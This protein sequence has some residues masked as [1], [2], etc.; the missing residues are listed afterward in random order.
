MPMKRIVKITFISLSI[1]IVLIFIALGF[2]FGGRW[3]S[4]SKLE[5][6]TS[7]LT[8]PS[9]AIDIYDSSNRTIKDENMFNSNYIKQT[10]I[11][12]HVKDAFIS[13]E[14]KTFYLHHG[15]NYKRIAKAVI[16][17]FKSM[18]LKEGASTISQQ[19]IKNTHL[20][21][22]KTF[23]RKIKEIALTKKLE[24]KYSKDEILEQ[25][26]NV[27]YFGNNCYGI[28]SAS[29]FYFSKSAH[30]LNLQE[31]AM[32][33][34]IIKSPGKYSPIANPSNCL[35]RR[36]LV[37]KEME[38]DDKITTQEYMNAKNSELG[39]KLNLKTENKLNS[40]S[41]ASIDEAE[42]IL[43]IPA[44]Q[45]ALR[46]YQI[47]TYQNNEKQQI[48]EKAFNSYEMGE[49][50]YAG[51][52]I[53]NQK[54]AVEAYTGRSAYK[55]INT[56]RQPGSCIKPILVY[57]PALNED[58]IT[59]C[60]QLLD[61]KTEIS[62]YTPRNIGDKYNGYVSAREALAKSINI[63]AVKVL[64]Y[65]GIDKAKAYAE[66][67]GIDFS[68][69]DDNY[70]LAL[71]GMCNGVNINQLATA[72]SCLANG[73]IY[74]PSH[75]VSYITDKNDKLIYVHRPEEKRVLREDASYLMTDMLRTSAKTGT[76]RKLS[77][78]EIDIASKT[79]TVGKSGVK[80]NLDAWNMSYTR[81]YTCGVWVG[82]L[83]NT[84]ITAVGG[85]LPTMIVKNY[86]SQTN[87]T[88]IFEQ[89]SSIVSMPI[90][91]TELDENHKVVLAS[92]FTP[93]RYT[94][95]ELFSRFNLPSE[96][97]NKFTQIQQPELKGNVIGDKA[98]LTFDAKNYYEYKLYRN[99]INESNL[100]ETITDKQG[101]QT[102]TVSM[103]LEREKFILVASFKSQLNLEQSI[104]TT[105]D[106]IK[107]I[108]TNHSH[109]LSQK[110]YV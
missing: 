43:G 104:S 84:P 57:A 67:L 110:W 20:S 42:K 90:D 30:D 33:A 80:D 56:K 47:H 10:A 106:L 18:N 32:L 59:P 54:H 48:L 26:L 52:V 35:T 64:S 100:I 74:A 12:N 101:K 40:Y 24:K 53:N 49:D 14:D 17:N 36:N 88:S 8:S 13:I 63:P 61:E 70:A 3:L 6:D 75:F 39:L 73:G 69:G 31:G 65:I 1:L 19:L 93:E 21:S 109:I 78:L 86:F 44:K 91:T 58:I 15:I 50:D 55:I 9:L 5:L 102:L 87:D 22:E 96:I 107:S 23:D 27:I 51:I 11:P 7:K 94:R 83:D 81:N 71:G 103:P 76:A 16:N 99:T 4:Y 77:D 82:N 85:G 72:Y 2:Y 34:G 29:N 28:E 60:T 66:S 105:I 37:L 98:I 68:D 79:G 62:G 45:I 108:S 95:K 89:P 41:E 25:Y 97:S 46:G 38:K 92:S